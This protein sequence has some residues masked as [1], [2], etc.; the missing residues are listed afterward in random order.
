[1]AAYPAGYVSPEQIA[2]EIERA[3]QKLGPEVIRV[4][5]TVEEDTSGE[6]AIYFRITL[7]DSAFGTRPSTEA[8]GR[9]TG[10][11]REILFDELRPNENWGLQP[12]FRFRSESEQA[13][14]HDPE[15]A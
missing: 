6:P 2:S 13:T 10:K 15:W 11:I 14:M 9:T 7:T 12:Y 4:K 5:Y 8:V 3:K 1:M